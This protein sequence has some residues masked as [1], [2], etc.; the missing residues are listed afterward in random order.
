MSHWRIHCAILTP[1]PIQAMSHPQVQL[2]STVRL[3]TR[4]M[5]I[6]LTAVVPAL[7]VIIY[8][9]ASARAR[10]REQSMEQSLRLA[11]DA[12]AQQA[13]VFN[14]AH[15][16]LATLAEFSVVRG[17][18]WTACN[19]L[20]ANVLRDHSG[21]VN[22]TVRG[23]DGKRLCGARPF[24][25]SVPQQGYAWFT[26]ILRE[27]KTVIGDYQLSPTD[28][29]PDIVV[30]HPLFDSTGAVDRV[31]VASIKLRDLGR[32]AADLKL[33]P[34]TV[35]TLFDRKHII[36]ARYPN[37]SGLI[38]TT[39]PTEVAARRL[40]AAGREI[41]T[42]TVAANG[43]RVL[44]VTMPV[45]G[46]LDTRLY[47]TLALD[48]AAAFSAVN[49][50]LR[51]QLLLLLLVAVGA[52]VA[53]AIAGE[54]FVLRPAAALYAVTTRVAGGDL[55]A[56]AALAHG[57]PGMAEL[58]TAVNSMA[59]ALENRQRERD[60]A[61]RALRASEDQYRQLFEESP[62]A[63][64]VYDVE[65]LIF[66]AANRAAVDQYGY[67]HDE[68]LGMTMPQLHVNDAQHRAKD[69][70]LI[71]VTT[72]AH[73][74]RWDG[75]QAR[76]VLIDNVTD[77]A[78]LEEQLRQTQRIEAIGMLAG[79]IA[80]DF[81]NL[82]TAI[83][84][85]AE[86][87]TDSIGEEHPDRGAV[88][89]IGRAAHRAADLTRQLLAFSRKQILAPRVVH[90]GE[91]VRDLTPMLRRLIG[92]T[93]HLKAIV[94]D[95]GN[96]RADPGQLEQVL[97][98]LVVNARDAMPDGGRLTIETADVLLNDE[99]VRV[100]P[101]MKP[102]H[103]VMLSVSDTG[104]G[105]DPAIQ[106]RIF[107]PFFTTKPK[108][109]GTGLGLSTVYGIVKQSGGYVCVRSQPGIGTT[110]Q[111][112]LPRTDEPVAVEPAP[113][114]QPAVR[115]DE[116][117]L[118]VEDEE[119]VGQ[120]TANVLRRCGYVV[121]ARSNPVDAVTF[122]R[123]YESEIHLLVSDVVLPVMNGRA[124][125]A[126]LHELH[127]ETRVLYMSGYADHAIVEDG[128]LAPDTPF[129]PKPFTAATLAHKVREVL[130]ANSILA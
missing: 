76:L 106:S 98:N 16:L 8:D 26:E 66:L 85:Y 51:R 52:V 31:L 15:R 20:L 53:A 78:Q 67:T 43:T 99:H 82:L 89:E 33:P 70:R 77:R 95:G 128:V 126:E 44:E 122:A 54:L 81:N 39:L 127:P 7:A 37:D 112:Y 2:F 104:H 80:H 9:Q 94:D 108:G 114:K 1:L 48:R 103:H 121:H 123:T 79:G 118:L 47:V 5:L 91:I 92:E 17:N 73:D 29:L 88:E 64:W 65:S 86:L 41:T 71:H 69:G 115:G 27:K 23:T 116:T 32:V 124:L 84:G 96:V 46:G 107:D 102:G 56:R 105:I 45:D 62:H 110:F 68:L 13:A 129:L 57:V 59:S 14:G 61:E 40:A 35:V 113:V 6:A 63:M 24:A 93:V 60:L 30:A 100:H 109:R 111:V 50:N 125:A 83:Q 58:A 87:L 12:A 22:L 75:R 11:H 72:R 90:L 3:R 49:Q 18:D 10:V 74:V 21:Y 34:G 117:I 101:F 119:T 120:F 130:D 97:M 19:T 38:G 55:T 25:F 42:E 28:G 36:L 4:L